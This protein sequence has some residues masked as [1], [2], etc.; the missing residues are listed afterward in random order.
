MQVKF[1]AEDKMGKGEAG[2]LISKETIFTK[3]KLGN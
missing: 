1:P 2:I 3:G